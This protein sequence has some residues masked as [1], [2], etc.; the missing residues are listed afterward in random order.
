MVF[1]QIKKMTEKERKKPERQI[2]TYV[3]G[4]RVP[5]L[6]IVDAPFLKVHRKK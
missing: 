3:N 1:L 6:A 5:Q 4:E 2:E